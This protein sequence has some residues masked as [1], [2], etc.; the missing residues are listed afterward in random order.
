[1]KII[2]KKHRLPAP[3]YCGKVSVSFTLCIEKRKQLFIRKNLVDEFTNILKKTIEKKECIVPVYCYMPDHQHVILHGMDSDINLLKIIG[4]YKQRTGYYLSQNN[5]DVKWQKNFYDKIIKK[6]ESLS[7]QVR[8]IL[9]NP[10]RKGLVD[11]WE[12]YLY[13]GSLSCNLNDIIEG[14]MV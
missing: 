5:I 7:T 4:E 10:V 8:Y 2:E 13:K 9:D 6:N 14:I 12:S 3:F 1:M 11:N